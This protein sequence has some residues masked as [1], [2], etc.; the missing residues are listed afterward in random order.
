MGGL[1]GHLKNRARESCA[2]PQNS[3]AIAKSPW[4]G[5]IKAMSCVPFRAINMG[6]FS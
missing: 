1:H 3:A 6:P 2:K 4:L 5:H